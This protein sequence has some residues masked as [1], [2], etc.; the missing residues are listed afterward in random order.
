MHKNVVSLIVMFSRNKA[1]TTLVVKPLDA[2]DMRLSQ[3]CISVCIGVFCHGPS[4]VVFRWGFKFFFLKNVLKDNE[5]R[6]CFLEGFI[7][8]HLIQSIIADKFQIIGNVW[9]A[10]AFELIVLSFLSDDACVVGEVCP[11]QCAVVHIVEEVGQGFQVIAS[12][13]FASFVCI[14]AHIINCSNRCCPNIIIY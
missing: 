11:R 13:L 14:H 7:I 10:L 2:A 6:Q 1:I 4:S 3:K 9:W 5:M 8:R 12:G